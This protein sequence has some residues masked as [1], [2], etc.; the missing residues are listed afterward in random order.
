[1]RPSNIEISWRNVNYREG[2][3]GVPM[4]VSVLVSAEQSKKRWPTTARR[5]RL[6]SILMVAVFL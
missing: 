2:E 1:M 4:T 3:R 6:K 5:A